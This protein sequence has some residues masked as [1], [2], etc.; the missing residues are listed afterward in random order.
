LTSLTPSRQ[1]PISGD[2][3]FTFDNNDLETFDGLPRP[4]GAAT[5]KIEGANGLMDNL[6]SMGLLPEDQASMGRLMMGMF[7]RAT[8]DDQL[9][10]T[11]EVNDQGHLIV[12]GQRIQ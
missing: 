4:L 8:G 11:V 7:A 12:N 6:V 3:A 5:V 10:T 2:G 9:E 1:L